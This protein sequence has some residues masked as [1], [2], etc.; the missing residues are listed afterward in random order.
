[1][2]ETEKVKKLLDTKCAVI[3][4]DVQNDFCHEKGACALRGSDVSGVKK[5]IPNLR[6]LLDAA[7]KNE[8]PVIYIQTI[9]TVETDSDAWAG[10]SGGNSAKVCRAGSW[11]IEF[12]E[13]SPAEGDIIVNKH[14][15]SAFINTRLDSVLRTLKVETLLMTGVATNVCVESTARDG[16]M[17]DYNI[18][19]VSDC[20][21]SFSKEAHA[22]TLQNI[23]KHFG[24]VSDSGEITSLLGGKDK[25]PIAI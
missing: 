7:H 24:V 8:I 16:Y 19:F 6:L 17:M 1:M 13:V 2:N 15:Y 23:D 25:M 21:A 22:M 9:H 14:R 18:L 12:Y 20:C 5:M 10:R 11:G 4:V 3:V